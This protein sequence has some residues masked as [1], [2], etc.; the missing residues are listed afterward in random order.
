MVSASHIPDP[1]MTRSDEA[2]PLI[3][4]PKIKIAPTTSS[5]RRCLRAPRFSKVTSHTSV[6][7]QTMAKSNR[8]GGRGHLVGAPN[9]SKS[10]SPA[11]LPALLPT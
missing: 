4:N 9:C 10:Q 11:D 3:K 6:S 7:Q 2:N 8:V 5:D 1:A